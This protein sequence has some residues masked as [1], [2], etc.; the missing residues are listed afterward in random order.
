[1]KFQVLAKTGS[2]TAHDNVEAQMYFLSKA[3]GGS[4]KPRRAKFDSK[5]FSKTWDA[6]GYFKLKDREMAMPGEDC[7]YVDNYFFVCYQCKNLSYFKYFVEI[8]HINLWFVC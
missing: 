5:I 3:E 1:M 6:A 8:H 4:D 7:T 2:V